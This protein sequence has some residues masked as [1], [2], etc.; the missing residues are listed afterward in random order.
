MKRTVNYI[1]DMGMLIALLVCG[2]TGIIKFPELNI[3]M[4]DST[5]LTVALLHDWA[6]VALVLLAVIHT[7]LHAKWLWSTT[8]KMIPER[9]KKPVAG[10]RL[11]SKIVTI[12]GVVVLMQSTY[13]TYARGHHMSNAT[14]PRGIDYTSVHLVDGTYTGTADGYSPGLTVSVTVKNGEIADISYIAHS[15]TPRWFVRVDN[16]IPAKIISTQ[17]TAIDTV[18]GA[19]ASCH[20]IMSAV[21]NALSKA[22]E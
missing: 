18:S 8:L 21:E 9:L 6:G 16:L 22:E 14:I 19:T 10:K 15:E 13:S 12:L 5:Y 4:S 17:S 20:G 2:I 7:I 1:V 11:S 3:I